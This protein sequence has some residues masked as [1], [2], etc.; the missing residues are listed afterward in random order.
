M[1]SKK[2]I[3]NELKITPSYL[4]IINK[5]YNSKVFIRRRVVFLFRLIDAILNVKLHLFDGLIGGY[6]EVMSVCR[7][8]QSSDYRGYLNFV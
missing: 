3:L 2:E 8:I 7:T 5:Y 4:L 1:L 6:I